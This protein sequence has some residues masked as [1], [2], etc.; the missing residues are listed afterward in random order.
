M[1]R[2]GEGEM[3]ERMINILDITFIPITTFAQAQDFVKI[4]R[5]EFPIKCK[6]AK[7]T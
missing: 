7:M 4:Y 2:E 6:F 3:R 5:V 1:G